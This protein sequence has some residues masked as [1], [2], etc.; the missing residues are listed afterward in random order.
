[1]ITRENLKTVTVSIDED[2][3]TWH[4]VESPDGQRFILSATNVT[5][6]DIEKMHPLL[7]LLYL[8]AP[9]YMVESVVYRADGDWQIAGECNPECANGVCSRRVSEDRTVGN[10]DRSYTLLL[11]YLNG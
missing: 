10:I 4:N 3:T 11:N 7:S 5:D 1:M 9:E 8:T 6:A 2:T